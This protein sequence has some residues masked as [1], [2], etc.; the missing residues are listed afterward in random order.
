M[1]YKYTYI[2]D[3]YN[4]NMNTNKLQRN[5]AIVINTC[6]GKFSIPEDGLK[7]M[8][9]QGFDR[10]ISSNLDITLELRLNPTL[11]KCIAMKPHLF[12]NCG[13]CLYIEYVE[14]GELVAGAVS[15][16]EHFGNENVNVDFEKVGKFYDSTK[17]I[18]AYERVLKTAR[19]MPNNEKLLQELE[20]CRPV[21]IV[22][23][24]VPPFLFEDEFEFEYYRYDCESDSD[25]DSDN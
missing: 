19:H 9:S 3:I 13:T 2:K 10:D 6:Y 12:E 11:V 24:N 1:N 22:P 8:V 7:Y 4:S 14:L 23:S 21:Q 16:D 5:V 15:I 17:R 18:L 25:S 20:Q